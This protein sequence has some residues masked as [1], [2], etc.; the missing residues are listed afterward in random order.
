MP[1][2]CRAPGPAPRRARGSTGGRTS[3]SASGAR[4]AR[5]T[6]PTATPGITSRTITRAAAPIAGAR[7]ASPAFCDDEQRLC[8]SLALWNGRD[9]ILK[10]RLFG[11]T[12]AQG[13]HGEDVKE[14]LL[15]PR[16]DADALVPEDALQVPAA[17][18]F[19]YARAGRGE[20]AARH[21]ASREYELL[22]TGVFDDDRYF[23]VFVEY[24]KAAPGDL[25]MR[26][27]AHNRG[28]EAAPLHVLP[29][30]W[31]RNTWSWK[32][33]PRRAGDPRRSM[34][35]RAARRP[36]RRCSC[37]P[38]YIEAT[39]ARAAVHR[40]RDQRSR[41]CGTIDAPG[42]LQGRVPRLHR[43]WQRRRREP[44]PH[45]GT[46]AGAVAPLADTRGRRGRRCGCG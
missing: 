7:T 17:R 12:N 42:L 43:R 21:A 15:L 14:H 30:L 44:G 36:S 4:C 8:L 31:F 41:G 16:R 19:P 26:V 23:D 18:H 24:A 46:K 1:P 5:T 28:P 25:L 40:Q 34:P 20:R 6:A 13:N 45:S 33:E 35:A 39:A 22:D 2:R 38:L 11:L 9:P 37:A 32:P 29:Q 10:E 27:T 3:A